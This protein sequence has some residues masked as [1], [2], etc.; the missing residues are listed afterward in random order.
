M[1][2]RTCCDGRRAFVR[3]AAHVD[4]FRIRPRSGGDRDRDV[5]HVAGDDVDDAAHEDEVDRRDKELA[6]AGGNVI[7]LES[8]V[9]GGENRKLGVL[10]AHRDFLE[11]R[12]VARVDDGA[13]DA[14]GLLRDA[15][16]RG[17]KEDSERQLWRTFA[18][19]VHGMCHH[20]QAC[21]L[22]NGSCSGLK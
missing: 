7:E 11:R 21:F 22:Q 16:R 6:A 18:A 15:A 14:A 5:E 1:L 17:Q 10:H 12:A 8:P 19:I 3:A 2:R 9:A 4:G 13:G 20:R